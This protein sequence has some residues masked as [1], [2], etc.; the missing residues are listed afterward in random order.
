MCG[1]SGVTA[2]QM[3]GRWRG[4]S[5][6]D[7]VGNEGKG[8]GMLLALEKPFDVALILAGTHDFVSRT[9]ESQR[10][11]SE[12]IFWCLRRLHESCHAAGVP[13]VV[14]TPPCGEGEKAARK[15][16]HELLARWASTSRRVLAHFDVEDLVPRE[17]SC[18]FWEDDHIH[19]SAD[20]QRRLG[21]R[22]AMALPALLDKRSSS[23]ASSSRHRSQSPSRTFGSL[24]P[25]RRRSLSPLRAMPLPTLL[26]SASAVGS[27]RLQGPGTHTRCARDLSPAKAPCKQHRSL[28]NLCSAVKVG[29]SEHVGRALIA[30]KTPSL[31][32]G[33]RK[34]QDIAKPSWGRAHVGGL[35]PSEVF[36]VRAR[37]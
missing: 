26:H 2:Q 36:G 1:L 28:L 3:L 15:G 33:P 25:S 19:L 18:G 13:T 9:P 34:P 24:S 8:L 20:G 30:G 32:L 37:S 21:N 27:L 23:S 11:R 22:L 35:P 16:L 31:V 6:K 4:S 12:T 7:A 10:L 17:P 29:S 5:L 14:L